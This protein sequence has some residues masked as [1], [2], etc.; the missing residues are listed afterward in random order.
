LPFPEDD[1]ALFLDID[2]TLADVAL[3]PEKAFIPPETMAAIRSISLSTNALALVSG[4]ALASIDRICQPYRFPAAGQ[5]GLEIRLKDDSIYLP[6]GRHDALMQALAEK[7]GE[8]H[9]RYPKLH[10]EYKGLSIAVHF[11]GESR[12]GPEVAARLQALVL[13]HP[14]VLCLQKGKMVCEIRLQG[15]G[16]GRAIEYMMRQPEFAGRK[17]VFV[18][19]D[20]SDEEG[21][22][23]VNA[24]SGISIKVGNGQTQAQ[25]RV[26]YLEELKTWLCAV[27]ALFNR[28]AQEA[29]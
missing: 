13:E 24:L 23:A 27:A 22:A 1:W 15:G 16:K 7:I 8:F 25:H 11:R 28:K 10:V 6:S 26:E 19:D 21:F 9:R 3:V 12:L 18:G 14:N 4:R 5:H 17:P 29:V 20:L 2:G